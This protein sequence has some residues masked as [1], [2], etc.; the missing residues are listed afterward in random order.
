MGDVFFTGDSQLHNYGL[1][2]KSDCFGEGSSFGSQIVG[3]NEMQTDPGG[4]FFNPCFL[5]PITSIDFSSF[6]FQMADVESPLF[7]IIEKRVGSA[8]VSTS[9]PL[10]WFSTRFDPDSTRPI[11]KSLAGVV[12]DWGEVYNDEGEGIYRLALFNPF[13]PS[14]NLYSQPF[15]L[16]EISAELRQIG[17]AH[18]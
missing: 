2:L 11:N 1:T 14:G 13:N 17:R 12:I 9:S 3:A 5:N 15:A 8:W 7:W 4:C 18:V 16:V 10:S 6:L